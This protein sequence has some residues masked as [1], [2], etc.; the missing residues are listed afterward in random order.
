MERSR[1]KTGEKVRCDY[2]NDK[3]ALLYC[4][5][6]SA[7]LC[8]FCDQHVHSANALSRKHLRSQICDNCNSE[9]VTV[10]CSTD[11]LVLCQE[12]DYD[13]HGSCNSSNSHDRNQIEGFSGCPSPLEL[14]S[15]WGIELEDKKPSFFEDL[16][17][18]W[19]YEVSSIDNWM[20]KNQG[21]GSEILR[22]L[23]VPSENGMMLGVSKKLSSSCGKQKQVILKQLMG[24]FERNRE[25]QNRSGVEL[26]N[27]VEGGVDFA[28]VSLQQE[29]QQQAPLT[30]LLMMNTQVDSEESDRRMVDGELLWNA[31]SASDRCSQIW[32]F[33]LGR[34]RGHEESGPLDSGYG[35]NDA[36]FLM[37]SYSEVLKDA[38]FGSTRGSG[39]S[40][41]L[42]SSMAHEDFAGFA[43]NSNNPTAN[44][45]TTTS[46]GNNY[47]MSRPSSGSGFGKPNFYGDSK[48]IHFCD[49][50]VMVRGESTTAA[51]TE[52]LAKNR[53]NAMLRYKEKKKTRRYEKHIRYESR[54]ARADTRKRVKGRFVKASEV[55]E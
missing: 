2:C 31:N 19:S 32:D 52:L 50:T 27:E 10:F 3:I 9:P 13:A 18:N 39:E 45:G 4:R 26:G 23:M 11:N 29:E 49:Q 38:S 42:S 28:N 25:M 20:Y 16:M 15:V 35:V 43:N 8:L 34:S 5:A 17:S 54:K 40:Y 1:S 14:A 51:D 47:T 21:S 48:D 24:L 37:R 22:D 53:G 44:Q 12:C 33:N 55:P 36:G 7:K 6:D 30:S 41:G 46:E